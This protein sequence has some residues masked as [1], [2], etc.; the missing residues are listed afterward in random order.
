ML[1]GMLM[2]MGTMVAGTDM[3]QFGFSQ[4]RIKLSKKLRRFDTCI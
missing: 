4:K 3:K 2:G 1:M